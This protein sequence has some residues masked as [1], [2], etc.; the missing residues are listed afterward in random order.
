M[1]K[2]SQEITL[3]R[4]GGRILARALARVVEHVDV[5][6]SLK[7]LDEYAQRYLT[8][9]GGHLA[10]RGYG[11]S[12]GAPPYP[13]TLCASVNDEVVH[14]IGTRDIV[15]RQGDIVGLDLG[16]RYPAKKGLYTDMAVTVGVGKI[17]PE[18]TQLMSVTQEALA[19]GIALVRDGQDL[20]NIS[21][22]IQSVAQAHGYGVIRDLAGHGIGYA[23]HE[24]PPIFNYDE[25][26]APRF[27]LKE[28]MTICIEPMITMGTWR[29]KV[30]SDG[31]TIRTEDGSLAAHFEH[32]ILVTAQG[33]EILTQV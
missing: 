28:G 32:T 6:V 9:A 10:F 19:Q 26:S 31:W 25:R 18:A 30:D 24:D 23:L 12:H 21:K 2:T 4:Q 20:K 33:S 17:S 5:G 27:I 29:V 15:L 1:V 8:E 3:M 11:G 13:A 16:V 7:Q 22:E 14:G